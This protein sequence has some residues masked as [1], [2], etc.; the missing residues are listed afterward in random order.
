MVIDP[1]AAV[2]RELRRRLA[3]TGLLISPGGGVS[4][5]FWSSGP[6]DRA[7]RV[8]GQLWSAGG[9]AR[10]LPAEFCAA[11][12]TAAGIAQSSSDAVHRE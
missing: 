10:A 7:T 11:P 9:V 3:A 12:V 5:A 8:L 1:A 2:A 6:L 4:D